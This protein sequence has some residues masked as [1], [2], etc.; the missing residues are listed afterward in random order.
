MRLPNSCDACSLRRVRCDAKRPC[1]ECTIHSMQCTSTRTPRKRGPKGPRLAT[2]R[3]IEEVQSRMQ[4]QQQQQQQRD[5]SWDPSDDNGASLSARRN[6]KPVTQSPCD[7]LPESPSPP[8]LAASRRRLPL[9]AYCEHLFI[10]R[11]RLYPIWPVVD[12]DELIAKLR[13]DDADY[14]AWALAASLCAATIAQLRLPGHAN[15]L[16]ACS[17]LRFVQDVQRSRELYDFRESDNVPSVLI[18]FFLHIYFANADKLHTAGVYLRESITFAHGLCLDQPCLYD[19]LGPRDRSLHL[20]VFWLL[21]ISERTYC[22]QNGLPVLLA[23][24]D[25]MPS[26]VDEEN[27]ASG[28]TQAFAGL[29]RIFAHLHRNLTRTSARPEVAMDSE[30]II[31]AQADLCIDRYSHITS[32]VQQVDLFVT[33]QWIRLLIWEHTMRHFAMSRDSRDD[34]FSLFLPV[35]IAYDLLSLFSTVAAGSIRAHGYGMAR[36]QG[37]HDLSKSFG[38]EDIVYSLRSVLL[39]VGG[40]RSVFLEKLQQRMDSS[41]LTA[42]SW[43]YL[44]L[45]RAKYDLLE[46]NRE[47]AETEPAPQEQVDGPEPCWLRLLGQPDGVGSTM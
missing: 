23:P 11:E 45:F 6:D 39:D 16:D 15:P 3:R 17:S 21:F 47:A 44:S 9:D 5:S 32:E 13:V 20:R 22:A 31:A 33:Q 29:T 7:P 12:V 36:A 34:A 19:S 42:S 30:A 28:I 4:Q 25:E 2:R 41:G 35:T 14:E 24:L 26:T 37:D 46:P 43:A 18:P 27:N 1:R 10:F 38:L 40:V 8:C